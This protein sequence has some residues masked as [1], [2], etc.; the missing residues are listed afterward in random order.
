VS[1]RSSRLRLEWMSWGACLHAD[2]EL[3]FP[4]VT[5]L[6][7]AGQ[8]R[9]AKEVCAPCPVRAACLAYALATRQ[10]HGVWGGA[11]GEERRAMAV[12]GNARG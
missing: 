10:R 2:P 5:G 4:A 7:G 11:T 1:D 12:P 8:A 3:F 9:E 6:T